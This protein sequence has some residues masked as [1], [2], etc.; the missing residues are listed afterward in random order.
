MRKLTILAIIVVLGL[1]LFI[2]VP[3]LSTYSYYQDLWAQ[4]NSGL[5]GATQT[6]EQLIDDFWLMVQQGG[7]AFTDW[8]NTMFPSSG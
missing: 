8:W 5:G 3:A 6:G 2:V 1:M 7:Q 4:V